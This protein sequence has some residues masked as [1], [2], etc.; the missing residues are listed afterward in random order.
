M[1]SINNGLSCP[2]FKANLLTQSGFYILECH[3]ERLARNAN[4]LEECYKVSRNARLTP[5][6]FLDQICCL[7]R[8]IMMILMVSTFLSWF[9]QESEKVHFN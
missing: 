9:T 6:F 2:F 5:L 4:D 8:Y 1:C 3:T 7:T